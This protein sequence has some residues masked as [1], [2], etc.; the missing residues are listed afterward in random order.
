LDD[1][2]ERVFQLLSQPV[3][4]QDVDDAEV[5]QQPLALVVPRW[6]AP[7]SENRIIK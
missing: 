4:L 1:C 5:E 2:F 3:A 7:G 6:N